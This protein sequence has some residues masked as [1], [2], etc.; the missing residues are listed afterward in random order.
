[1][2]AILGLVVMDTTASFTGVD[3][4]FTVL[5]GAQLGLLA[6]LASRPRELGLEND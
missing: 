6:L 2:C 5:F 4:R 3:Q 1:M